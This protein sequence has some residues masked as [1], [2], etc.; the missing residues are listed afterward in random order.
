MKG[1][2]KNT[3]FSIKNYLKQNWR[4]KLLQF[5]IPA[6]QNTET[7][8]KKNKTLAHIKKFNHVFTVSA[9]LNNLRSAGKFIII[10]T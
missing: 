10:A 8:I 1:S 5:I 6:N 2:D 4:I 3:A 7:H 9:S